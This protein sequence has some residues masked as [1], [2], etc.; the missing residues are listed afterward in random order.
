MGMWISDSSKPHGF[1]FL[2]ESHRSLPQNRL[3]GNLGQSLGRSYRA[4]QKVE[5]MGN[6]MGLFLEFY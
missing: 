5:G 6:R 1:A 2:S 3:P 4:Q